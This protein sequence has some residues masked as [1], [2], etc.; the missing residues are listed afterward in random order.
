MKGISVY[1]EIQQL[2]KLGFSQRKVA[3][4]LSIS[5]ETVARYWKMSLESYQ[6]NSQTICRAKALS[7]H[8]AVILGWLK[9]YPDMSSAQVLD[10][11]KENYCESFKERTVSRYVRSLRAKHCIR[12]TA[13]PRSYEAVEELPP[14]VQLQ[15]DFGEQYMPAADGKRVKVWFAAFVLSHSRYKYIEFLD[16]PFCA[17]DLVSV[18]HNCFRYLGG[19]PQELVFDQDSV[20]CVAENYGEILHTFEFEKLRQQCGFRVYM[21]RPADPESKGKIER[22][23]Q[24]VKHNFLDHRYY[25][26]DVGVLN[27][28]VLEWLDR[29][30]NS[31]PHG[32]TKRPPCELFA[33][34][35]E[36]LKPLP[37]VPENRT[38]DIFRT[39]R[40]DNT[41]IYDSS[42]YSLPLGTFNTQKEVCVQVRDGRLYITT[43]FGDELCDHPLAMARGQLVKSFSHCRD[44]SET[45]DA[46]QSELDTLL[47]NKA[48]AYLQK[49][50]AEMSRYARDQFRLLSGLCDAYGVQRVLEAIDFCT[51]MRLV[52][53]TYARDFLKFNEQPAP[54]SETPPIPVSD[55]KYH[56]TTQKRSLEVYAKA[57]ERK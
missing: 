49:I 17:P 24:Y 55:V 32:T 31:N 38:T 28:M 53:A 13:P 39:V 15:V 45:L 20:V 35:R 4:R 16:R 37:D 1:R 47:E 50:R 8:E 56:L 48:S 7:E 23:V 18:C 10:W 34:E 9:Q 30:G 11:L 43:T 12:K 19:M 33:K 5:R 52:S 14:G 6:H 41:I 25:P 54:E 40:K 51:A 21:C 26:D 3:R 22:V 46:V 42:R 44:T 57:G 29:T 36:Y 27:T 2:K